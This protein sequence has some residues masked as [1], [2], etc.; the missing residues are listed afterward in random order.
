MIQVVPYITGNH[1]SV[2][3]PMC[4][5]YTDVYPEGEGGGEAESSAAES[6]TIQTA[7]KP[8]TA[9]QILEDRLKA[10]EKIDISN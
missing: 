3:C 10:G 4:V 7:V 9:E 1:F 5:K 6:T 8:R 2:A